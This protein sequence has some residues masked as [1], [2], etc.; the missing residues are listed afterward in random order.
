MNIETW[1]S[2]VAASLILTVTPGPSIFLGI[3]HSVS[4][5]VRRV[6][7][8][9]LGDITAN[10]LQMLLVS[11]GLG[12][13]IST[14]EYAF[15]FVKWF[16]VITLAYLGVKM[17]LSKSE[18]FKNADININTRSNLKL[19]ISGFMVAAGNPKAI[20]FFTA[21]LP[22]FIDSSKPVLQQLAI[23]CPTMAILDF[24]LVMLYALMAKKVVSANSSRINTINKVSGGL[25][26]G[27]SGLLAASNRPAT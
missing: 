24:T 6:V 16:G 9:A 11:I 15:N 19:Y 7:Y 23:L 8:T 27:A 20:V 21:F 25:L 18:G 2:F 13:V 26:V 3:A 1:I 4:F 17:F 14:S 12:V 10:F 22:Q 5:G